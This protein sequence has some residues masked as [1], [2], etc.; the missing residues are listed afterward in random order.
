MAFGV[1]RQCWPCLLP[2]GEMVWDRF[3]SVW[4]SVFVGFSQVVSWSDMGQMLE[5]WIRRYSVLPSVPTTP[6]LS[7]CGWMWPRLES[8]VRFCICADHAYSQLASWMWPR[9]YFST[10]FGARFYVF[11]RQRAMPQVCTVQHKHF[12]AVIFVLPHY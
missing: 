1:C 5:R 12:P 4:Q 8:G 3:R 11:Y 2:A 6:L 10:V 9:F 7:A